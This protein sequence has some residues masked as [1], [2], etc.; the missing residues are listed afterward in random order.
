MANIAPLAPT[1]TSPPNN[2]Y[3]VVSEPNVFTWTFNDPGDIQA[4][5]YFQFKKAGGVWLSTG[6]VSTALRSYTLPADSWEEPFL[7]EWQVQTVDSGGMASPYSASRFVNTIATIPA[8]TITAPAAAAVISTTPVTVEWTVAAELTQDAYRVMAVSPTGTVYYD[9]GVVEMSAAR[10]ALVPL[11]MGLNN[12]VDL[13]VRLRYNDH[14]SG[15][16]AGITVTNGILPPEI[17]LLVLAQVEGKPEVV[18][19]VTN[20][21]A[22]DANHLATDTWDL[23]RNGVPIARG[24]APNASF[25]DSKVGAGEVDYRAVARTAGG[26]TATSY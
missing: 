22:S 12:P 1:L 2:S 14:W 20:P 4:E 26:G 13:D 5:Y 24:L 15:E 7:Y 18:V 11:P 21:A 25:T 3:I 9:S 8:P 6:Q 10:S 16:P 19:S 23:T 17:P